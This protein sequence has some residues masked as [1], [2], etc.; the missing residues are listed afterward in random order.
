MIQTEARW[1]TQAILTSNKA[2][3]EAIDRAILQITKL[4]KPEILTSK[5]YDWEDL[6][7]ILRDIRPD[8]SGEKFDELFG[9][10]MNGELM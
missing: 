1:R 3:A 5:G 8:T 2:I 9:Q 4:G 7:E 10:F 6:L